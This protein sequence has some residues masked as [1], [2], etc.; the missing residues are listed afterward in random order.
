M[1]IDKRTLDLAREWAAGVIVD[2]ATETHAAAE[3]IASLP[4][5]WVDAEL[6]KGMA[7]TYTLERDANAK[8]TVGWQRNDQVVKRLEALL[9]APRV[10]IGMGVWAM[11]AERGKVMI[12]S[13]RPGLGEEVMVAQEIDD[14]DSGTI[15]AWVKHAN[16]SPLPEDESDPDPV[17]DDGRKFPGT[18]GAVEAPLLGPPSIEEQNTIRALFEIPPIKV[19]N[20]QY[21][22]YTP[23]FDPSYLYCDQT[24]DP[25]IMHPV[26]KKW[27]FISEDDGG[28]DTPDAQFGPYTRVNKEGGQ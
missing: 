8:G 10:E 7:F 24:G 9:P 25:W 14:E 23:E 19:A 1:N 12:V 18:M 15:L 16:L 4:D 6:V 26:S 17:Y 27:N 28:W 21:D 5:Q 3:V 22:E 13:A 11:H 2:D 20:P